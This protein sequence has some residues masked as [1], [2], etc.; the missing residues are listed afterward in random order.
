MTVKPGLEGLRFGRLVASHRE[1]EGKRIKWVCACDCGN[2]MSTTYTCLTSG[3]TKSCGCLK[4]ERTASM[5]RAL[6]GRDAVEYKTWIAIKGRC[7][8]QSHQDYPKYGGRGIRVSKAWLQSYEQFLRDMGPRPKGLSIDRI[9]VNGDY[10]FGNCRWATSETQSNNKRTN[11]YIEY[12]GLT[13]TVSQWAKRQGMTKQCL[14]M[15]LNAGWS[16]ESA[17]NNAPRPRAPNGYPR[18]RIRK[19]NQKGTND[20]NKIL[21]TAHREV[22]YVSP[23]PD[24]A[25]RPAGVGPCLPVVGF[26]GQASVAR[27]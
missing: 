1:G 20:P 4:R 12:E 17:L 6:P 18:A 25:R 8:N 26:R 2:S 7:Y 23:I 11:R 21:A 9:D 3:D 27:P 16:V 19:V 5:G 10:E 22:R 14:I 24:P 13:L 15:R